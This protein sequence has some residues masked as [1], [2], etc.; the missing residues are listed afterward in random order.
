MSETETQETENLEKEIEQK[1]PD[2]ENYE[3]EKAMFVKYKGKMPSASHSGLNG[4]AYFFAKDQYIPVDKVDYET[5]QRKATNNPHVWEV[6]I[7]PKF[8]YRDVH[9]VKFMGNPQYPEEITLVFDDESGEKNRKFIFK[10]D[11]WTVVRDEN[12]ASLMSQKA[13]NNPKTWS[14][15]LDKEKI[16]KKNVVG[17]AN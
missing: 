10:K 6:D 8:K 11:A 5:Y 16:P 15:Q 3:F 4:T 12:I 14:Y 9:K 7:R 13:L 1:D 17:G 2:L